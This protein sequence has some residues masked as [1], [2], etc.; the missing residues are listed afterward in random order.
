VPRISSAEKSPTIV[1]RRPSQ[2]G[3]GEASSSRIVARP[4]PSAM[5]APRANGELYEEGLVGL[6]VR[7]PLAGTLTV[8]WVWPG[9]KASSPER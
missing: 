7:I 1:A 4:L 8:F 5:V 9:E 6:V 3:P 2:V